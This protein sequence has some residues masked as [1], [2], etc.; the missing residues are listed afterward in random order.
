MNKNNPLYCV[1]ADTGIALHNSGRCLLCCHSQTYFQD[2][3]GQDLYLDTA[4]L[5]QMWHSKTRKEIQ[6][7][8]DNGIQHPNCSACWN[9][10]L[11]GRPSRR[12]INNEQFQDLEITPAAPQ[13]ID[14][15]PGNT[16]NLACRTCWPEVSSKWYKDY[17]EIEGYKKQ[18][19][20]KE[21]LA[22]WRRI[23][24][25][26]TQDN[27]QLWSDL[28]E[29]L[30][31]I[32]Y[33]DIFGAEPMLLDRLFDILKYV[34]EQDLA[35]NQGLHINTNATIWNQEYIDLLTK[36]KKVNIDLS[37]DGIG[38][39]YDYIRYGVEWQQV[40]ENIN[41]Y[42][43]L[44]NQ[45]PNID[46]CVCITVCSLNVYYLDEIYQYFADRNIKAF[47]NLVHHPEYINVRNLPSEIKPAIR[48][49][50][51]NYNQE[52]YSR[53]I[54]AVLDFMDMPTHN[55]QDKWAEFKDKTAKL[56]H[57]REQN[58]AV[59]FPEFYQLVKDYF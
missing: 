38:S 13:L 52:S 11:A 21:Y 17:W 49:K 57:L 40:K 14:L 56:D 45:Y 59:T 3:Q 18:P 53:F 24:S 4:R 23:Q 12:T 9:E 44:E 36:F 31:N 54:G 55:Q 50:L 6:K 43:H 33:Y 32:V 39:H 28:Q 1:W 7:S 19:D 5:D 20:Y 41:R 51:L 2:D 30:S 15:K 8:L 37:I 27:Q 42:K 22:S 47:F 26:Y 25:S 46:I 29:W 48:S 34:V 10:E 35:S 58:F 16:C